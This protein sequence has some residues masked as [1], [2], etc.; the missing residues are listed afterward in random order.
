MRSELHFLL[1]HEIQN[2]SILTDILYFFLFLLF[3]CRNWEKKSICNKLMNGGSL[4]GRMFLKCMMKSSWVCILKQFLFCFNCWMFVC[5]H[6]QMSAFLFIMFLFW[7]IR[8]V[9]VWLINNGW[10]VGTVFYVDLLQDV[11]QQQEVVH[12]LRN[13]IIRNGNFTSN[14]KKYSI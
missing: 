3:L 1:L 4:C 6:L 5:T 2:M 8:L 13:P 11:L 14:T 12:L 7:N 10:R 9:I